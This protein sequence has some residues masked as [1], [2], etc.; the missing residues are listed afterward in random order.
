MSMLAPDVV[1]TA[2]SGGKASAAR[3]PVIG[4]EKV[5]RAVVGLV[6]RA[7]QLP[8]VR[9]EAVVCNAAPALLFY[10]GDR[11]EGVFTVEIVDG[12]ISNFYAMRNPDK[13]VAVATARTISRS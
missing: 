1:W 13:L 6:G 11:L 10:Q 2:D 3:R 12:K 7:V 5:A 4:A 8:D 9:V